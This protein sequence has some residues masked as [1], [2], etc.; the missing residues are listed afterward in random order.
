MSDVPLHIASLFAQAFNLTQ[1]QLKVSLQNLRPDFIFFDLAYWDPSIARPLGIKLIYFSTVSVSSHSMINFPMNVNYKIDPPPDYPSSIFSM[2][3]PLYIAR[4]ILH[5]SCYFGNGISFLERLITS[6]FGCQALC[7]HG[8]RELEGPFSDFMEKQYKKPISLIGPVLPKPSCRP[9]DEKWVKWLGGFKKGS[10]VYC[11][12][13]SECVLEKD[14]FQEL[15]L[16]LELTGL[17]FI[18]RLKPPVGVSTVEEALPKGFEE[19]TRGKRSSSWRL[20]SA[21]TCSKSPFSRM[22]C[23]SL[24]LWVNVGLLGEYLSSSFGAP[25]WRPIFQH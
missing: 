8:C 23:E 21:R 24:W 14:Q 10:V 17:P 16:G 22:F 9:L 7:F 2:K 15:V 1:D 11:A 13:G 20:G 5:M 3:M 12:F 25:C 6:I 18:V 19:R 4:H